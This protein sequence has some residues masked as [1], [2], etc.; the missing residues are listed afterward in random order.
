MFYTNNPKYKNTKKV[1]TRQNNFS[2]LQKKQENNL[3][4]FPYSLS[5]NQN[6]IR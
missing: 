6:P 4:N 3:L 2:N 5:G 1:L